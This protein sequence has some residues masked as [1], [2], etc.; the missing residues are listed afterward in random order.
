MDKLTTA[1]HLSDVMKARQE[2]R[3]ARAD[4]LAGRMADTEYSANLAAAFPVIAP[5]R[6]PNASEILVQLKLPQ[7]K[8][9]SI[10]IPGVSR[11]DDKYNTRMG[12]VIAIGPEA[13]RNRKTLEPW[14]TGAQCEVGDYVILPVH[15]YG[16]KR[17]ER[18]PDSNEPVLCVMI[19]DTN[20]LAFARD[21][22]DDIATINWSQ[23]LN[24]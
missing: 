8:V 20:S 2:L 11:I 23:A 7:E 1:N 12:K 13:F 3:Q 18:V 5:N 10:F 24:S 4:Y 15:H 19:D 6:E 9:G 22:L 17:F 16:D 21:P 14:P